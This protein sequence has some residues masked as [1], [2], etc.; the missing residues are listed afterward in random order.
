MDAQDEMTIS[1]LNLDDYFD[2]PEEI[3]AYIKRRD[4]ARRYGINLLPWE[5][6]TSPGE[7]A[8]AQR[9]VQ[10]IVKQA[11]EAEARRAAGGTVG[12]PK[13]RSRWDK[14]GL[15]YDGGTKGPPPKQGGQPVNF[16]PST[17]NVRQDIATSS[18]GQGQNISNSLSAGTRAEDQPGNPSEKP[19]ESAL[20]QEE[21]AIK[22]L[23][24]KT[25]ADEELKELISV[26]QILNEELIKPQT[27]NPRLLIQTKLAVVEAMIHYAIFRKFLN[28]KDRMREVMIK[29]HT[30]KI[31]ELIKEQF[32]NIATSQRTSLC[33]DHPLN[34]SKE[35]HLE[36][37][38][39]FTW[40]KVKQPYLTVPT[41][42]EMEDD[43]PRTVLGIKSTVPL[44]KRGEATKRR[45]DVNLPSVEDRSEEIREIDKNLREQVLSVTMRD[46]FEGRFEVPEGML[47][48]EFPPGFFDP[49]VD[50]KDIPMSMTF[51]KY[52]EQ[53][54][55][56]TFPLFSGD[57]KAAGI[58]FPAFFE[59]FRRLVHLKREDK[60][61][62]NMKFAIL[63]SLMEKNSPAD[64]IFS[65]FAN[66]IDKRSAYVY[67]IRQLWLE[68]GKDND[69][70]LSKAKAALK[71][72]KPETASAR[73]QLDFVYTAIKCFDSLTQCGQ[74]D[75]QAAK[76]TCKHILKNLDKQ[77]LLKFMV[78]KGINYDNVFNYYEKFPRM[79]LEELPITLRQ[80]YSLDQIDEEEDV[81]LVA[82]AT[83]VEHLPLQKNADGKHAGYKA[84]SPCIFC[85]EKHNWAKCPLSVTAKR[86]AVVGK[87]KCLNC[88]HPKCEGGNS[89]EKEYYCKH[90][91]DNSSLPKH[92]SFVCNNPKNPRVATENIHSEAKTEAKKPKIEAKE[93]E[94]QRK[95]E[96]KTPPRPYVARSAEEGAKL[97]SAL[98]TLQEAV[99]GNHLSETAEIVTKNAEKVLKN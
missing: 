71:A 19:E 70:L 2:T 65:Q 37:M 85:K 64:H 10:L 25:E 42:N 36:V 26:R 49:M 76:K 12:P 50:C 30:D 22:A 40:L 32:T 83:P 82:K 23:T 66:R 11:E 58:S 13:V 9:R 46:V 91:K 96:A 92:S 60:V 53:T 18:T 38:K 44:R 73:D 59:E 41:M 81:A 29:Y 63:K 78:H 62:I 43:L 17:S 6:F 57:N 33:L 20:A 15:G 69:K 61:P 48:S 47:K 98:A 1:Y 97:I 7:A 31:S 14:T 28:G 94:P 74:D 16:V 39:F 54:H 45:L 80:I 95:S 67:A 84:P 52:F 93:E 77:T 4:A 8:Q 51:Q 21:A 87:F 34:Y 56:S 72:T 90:C 88:F 75:K 27:T 99:L 5:T 79:S 68:F 3:E 35:D 24:A 86:K 55:Q 89:C